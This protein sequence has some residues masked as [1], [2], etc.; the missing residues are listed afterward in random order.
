MGCIGKRGEGRAR[1]KIESQEIAS[2]NGAL[3][4]GMTS[5]SSGFKLKA[6]LEG[7]CGRRSMLGLR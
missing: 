2:R 7:E 6:L 3:A 5:K 1:E 4:R